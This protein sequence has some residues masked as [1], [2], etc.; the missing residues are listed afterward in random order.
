MTRD[1]AWQLGL[2]EEVGTLEV[3][4]RAD[5]VMLSHNP[6]TM[7]VERLPEIEVLGTWL[8]GQPVDA[9]PISQANARWAWRALAL[10]FGID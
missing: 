5:L 8:D 10:L 2:E 9:R 7:P 4:K 3:G 1:A 6:A